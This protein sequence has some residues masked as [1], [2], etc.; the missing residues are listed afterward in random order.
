MK[1]SK[2]QFPVIFAF[3]I[4]VIFLICIYVLLVWQE[5]NWSLSLFF[6]GIGKNILLLMNVV[7]TLFRIQM[8]FPLP[9]ESILNLDFFVNINNFL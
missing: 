1:N 9:L 8:Q 5:G 2:M 7:L 3:S 6:G 4:A